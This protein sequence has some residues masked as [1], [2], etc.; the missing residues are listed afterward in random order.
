MIHLNKGNKPHEFVSEQEFAKKYPGL[1]KALLQLPRQ[2]QS[3]ARREELGMS[4][5]DLSRI[6]GLT[7]VEIRD[8]EIGAKALEE[9]QIKLIENGLDQAERGAE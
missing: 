3:R 7:T 8:F 5:L 1:Q 6:T 9:S 2:K 4:I